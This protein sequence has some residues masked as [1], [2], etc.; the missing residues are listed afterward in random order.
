[1]RLFEE[2]ETFGDRTS[3]HNE[4]SF[5]Y[6]EASCRPEMIRVK[7]LLESWFSEYPEEKKAE[8]RKRLRGEKPNGQ[9]LQVARRRSMFHQAF[10]ELY[11]YILL[12]RLGCDVIVEPDISQI[13][14]QGTS[15]DFLATHKATGYSFY[16]EATVQTNAKAQK[17][18][19]FLNEI[20]QALDSIKSLDYVICP[21]RLRIT[22]NK[23]TP[24]TNRLVRYVERCLEDVRQNRCPR[25]LSPRAFPGPGWKLPFRFESRSEQESQVRPDR[26][27]KERVY[28]R[29]VHDKENIRKAINDKGS[30]YGH[31][32][33]P[34]IIAVNVMEHLVGAEGVAQALYG[35]ISHV[36]NL[37]RS[38]HSVIGDLE[39]SH[40]QRKQDGAFLARG[41]QFTRVSAVWIASSLCG[42]TTI[43]SAQMYQFDNHF[44]EK[45]V[46]PDFPWLRSH[47]IDDEG[48]LAV[49]S[50]LTPQE[51]FDIDRHWPYE[52]MFEF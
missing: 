13:Q 25:T 1:M 48:G 24:S 21:D 30:H 23:W 5:D 52:N 32:D 19:N 10:F 11:L 2:V 8:L 31:L 47:Y 29:A 17:Y 46:S 38:E 20:N 12:R 3:F 22:S 15:P 18:D 51:L 37:V 45:R 28:V 27:L 39:F 42:P 36:F 33:H 4:S 44:A 16:V 35:S 40:F 43:G 50:G 7:D 49:K 26:S 14:G 9:K 6:I 41:R 34:F